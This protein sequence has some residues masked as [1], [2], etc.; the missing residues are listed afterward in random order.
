VVATAG[1]VTS[2]VFVGLDAV[3]VL[4]AGS[5]TLS[6]FTAAGSVLA[7]TGFAAGAAAVVAGAVAESTFAGVVAGV[8][9]WGAG[10]TDGA[11]TSCAGRSCARRPR[12]SS[13][14]CAAAVRVRAYPAAY[15]ARTAAE[16][17]VT[18]LLLSQRVE[19]RIRCRLSVESRCL[20]ARCP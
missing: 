5:A 4:T 15:T 12:G 3:S 8:S 1:G 11:A 10:A 17:R 2:T 6:A 18:R 13:A 20:V 19:R 16:P 14:N 9:I 7:A